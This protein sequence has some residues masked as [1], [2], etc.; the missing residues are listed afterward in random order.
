MSAAL[1]CNLDCE[2]SWAG[3]G[4]LKAPVLQA[5]SRAATL[6]AVLGEAGD[7]L[8]TP[9]PV[10]RAGLAD[11]ITERVELI[12]GPV[13]AGPGLAWGRTEAVQH[14]LPPPRRGGGA[15]A[16]PASPDSAAAANDKR[17]AHR[18][19]ARLEAALPGAAI[20]D[21]GDDL[22]RHIAAMSGDPRWV[23]KAPWSASGRGRIIRRGLPDQAARARI[24][25]L[26]AAGGSAVFEPYVRRVSD[27]GVCASVDAGQ[28]TILG[29]HEIFTDPTGVFHGIRTEAQLPD[30]ETQALGRACVATG[31][32]IAE[33]GYHG[34]F[35]IDGFRW[36]DDSGAS[37]L[38]PLSEINARLTF[39]FIAR[40]WAEHFARPIALRFGGSPPKDAVTLIAGTEHD[41]CGAWIE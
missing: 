19:A 3:G 11:L 15:W 29:V 7:R 36:L 40:A 5:V 23:L 13:P 16:A 4:T 10:D 9:A 35:G 21:S 38:A 25:R 27:F 32:A 28:V 33:V 6:A 26:L 8:W 18:V 41:R 2:L 30:N 20:V 34:P 31:A 37:H 24:E 14:V 22:E 12:S 39:G 17:L 1:V